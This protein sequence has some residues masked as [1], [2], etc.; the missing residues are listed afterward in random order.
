MSSIR[1]DVQPVPRD[2]SPALTPR[3]VDIETHEEQVGQWWY[4]IDGQP[5]TTSSCVDSDLAIA[6]RTMSNEL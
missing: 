6:P 4:Q 3:C 2:P 1:T 5:V